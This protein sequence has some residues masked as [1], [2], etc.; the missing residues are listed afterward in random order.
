MRGYE[1]WEEVKEE[2]P[3]TL[4]Q[5][6]IKEEVDEEARDSLRRINKL[7]LFATHYSCYGHPKQ[8]KG[9][10]VMFS[11]HPKTEGWMDLIVIPRIFK[12]CVLRDV[13]YNQG[14]AKKVKYGFTKE[15]YLPVHA[16]VSYTVWFEHGEMEKLVDIIC[17]E[18]SK[19]WE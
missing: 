5:A 14:I 17:E 16:F 15:T 1:D 8:K 4:R 13:I 3:K 9:G 10:Y 18:Y 7:P 19:R 6:L 12:E 11:S 2:A